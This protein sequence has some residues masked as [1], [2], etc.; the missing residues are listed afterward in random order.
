M[1]RECL[2]RLN[3]NQEKFEQGLKLTTTASHKFCF[4]LSL[5]NK[6]NFVLDHQN[7]LF[8]VDECSHNLCIFRDNPPRIENIFG[9]QNQVCLLS[10]NFF[11]EYDMLY[12]F[13]D[14]K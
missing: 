10:K 5:E 7:F 8:Q 6:K 14:M 2:S 13:Q 3:L 1:K 4:E 9:S 12:L 11:F